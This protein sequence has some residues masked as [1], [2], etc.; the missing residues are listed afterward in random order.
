LC[1]Q[2]ARD[3]D[4]VKREVT[5]DIEVTLFIRISQSGTRNAAANARVIQL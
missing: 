2:R 4:Q 1:V 5:K 3:T